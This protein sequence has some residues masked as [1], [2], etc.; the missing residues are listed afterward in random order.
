M[1][2]AKEV[3]FPECKQI[4]AIIVIQICLFQKSNSTYM[5]IM[6]ALQDFKTVKHILY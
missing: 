4:S 3:E 5:V 2:A 1:Q 6:S